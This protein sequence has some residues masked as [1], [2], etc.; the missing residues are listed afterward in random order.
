[1]SARPGTWPGDRPAPQATLP[2]LRRLPGGS[3]ERRLRLLGALQWVG[4]LGGAG[5]WMAQ[6]A[7]GWGLTEA[8][9]GAGGRS[10][11]IDHDL[12]QTALAATAAALVAGAMACAGLVL[13]R[14]RSL[15]FG[16][17]PPGEEPGRGAPPGSRLRFFAAA[18][19]VVNLLL[20]MIIAL[21]G[22]ASVAGIACRQA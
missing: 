4:L 20:L 14:T 21:D 3:T 9:C 17:G 18:A 11:G 10:F 8:A 1:M 19:L 16:G 22:A 15:G 6:H 13:W 5:V 2:D 7:I 12:W